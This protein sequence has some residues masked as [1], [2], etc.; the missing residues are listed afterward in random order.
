M[1]FGL[2]AIIYKKIELWH[3]LSQ[4]HNYNLKHTRRYFQ[5]RNKYPAVFSNKIS[6]HDV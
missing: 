6:R 1:N 2:F 4:L 3:E 5:Y